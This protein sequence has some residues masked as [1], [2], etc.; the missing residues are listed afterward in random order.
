M[1]VTA[2]VGR[3]REF[4]CA[5][6]WGPHGLEEGA[7]AG[8]SHSAATH[9]PGKGPGKAKDRS[10]AG[11]GEWLAVVCVQMEVTGTA[12]LYAVSPG[13]RGAGNSVI[14]LRFSRTWL[15]CLPL[16]P[17]GSPER[18]GPTHGN[19]AG[20]GS[21]W[22]RATCVTSKAGFILGLWCWCLERQRP[23]CGLLKSGSLPP[24]L[25]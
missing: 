20:E 10:Q 25:S 13:V 8:L 4:P 12:W 5:S 19:K 1:I 23:C 14:T 18:P 15:P 2:A 3:G 7:G 24:M 9:G 11:P 6:L 22:G 21:A 16:L 17:S